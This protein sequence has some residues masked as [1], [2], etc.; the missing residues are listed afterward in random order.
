MNKYGRHLLDLYL[1]AKHRVLNRRVHGDFQEHLTYKGF[2]GRSTM[3]FV[4]KFEKAF[5][6]EN[7]IQYVP[8]QSLSYLSDHK[9]VL[10]SLSVNEDTESEIGDKISDSNSYL[11]ERAKGF[12]WQS[13]A[14][15]EF[16]K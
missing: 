3:D 16:E 10:L 7:I 8:V 9:P 12:I 1:E 13:F 5:T 11:L 14:E 4:L 15:K 6:K 2:H